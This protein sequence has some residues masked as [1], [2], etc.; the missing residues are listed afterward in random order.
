M[1]PHLAAGNRQG[2]A[3]IAP[4]HVGWALHGNVGVITRSRSP[5]A[6]GASSRSLS[7]RRFEASISAFV[8][9]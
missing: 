2:A 6:W 5:S 8:S 4:Q 1:D 9:S 7:R 3:A